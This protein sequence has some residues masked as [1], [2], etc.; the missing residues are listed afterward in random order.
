M[1]RMLWQHRSDIPEVAY[2]IRTYDDHERLLFAVNTLCTDLEIEEEGI[3][4][5]LCR[6]DHNVLVP[7]ENYVSIG[8]Y[9]R[10]HTIIHAIDPCLSLTVLDIPYNARNVFKL[11]K[12]L[13]SLYTHL[14]NKNEA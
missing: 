9:I 10:P 3:H 1:I 8:C 14:G 5:V 4:E 11:W 2:A 7:G 12:N 13:V 6:F